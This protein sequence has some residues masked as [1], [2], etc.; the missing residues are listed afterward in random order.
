MMEFDDST[1]HGQCGDNPP[2]KFNQETD[3]QD[4]Q[5]DH[6]YNFEQ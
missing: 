3:S 4:N 6:R 5:A 2:Q 1:G